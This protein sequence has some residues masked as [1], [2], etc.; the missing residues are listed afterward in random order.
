MVYVLSKEGKP[1][2][3]TERHAYVRI[4]LKSGKARVVNRL[5]FTIQLNYETTDH[6]QPVILGIDPGRTNIGIT[7]VNEKGKP[8]FAANVQTRNKEIPKLMKA[9]KAFRRKHRQM[10]RR[11]KRQRRAKANGTV[12]RGGVIKRHLPSYGEEKSITCKVI[13]NKQARFSNRRRPDGWLTP[14]A[15]QLLE[16]HMNLVKKILKFLPVS[17]ANIELNRF[18]FM[19]LDNPS[20]MGKDFQNGPLKGFDDNVKQAVYDFQEGRCLLCGKPVEVYHHVV[21][22]HKNGSE[23]VQNRVGLCEDCH[24]LVHTDLTVEKQLKEL[25]RGLRKQ[26]DA[27]GVLNQ[28]SHA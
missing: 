27:L 8:L 17:Q 10:R 13:K 14:T 20:V 19:R 16:T 2:M 26:Y 5:P 3:P 12:V 28:I 22:R 11:K 6:V 9:R 18:A 4:L 1:L 24:K 23:T 7:A 15:R 25:N 21:E